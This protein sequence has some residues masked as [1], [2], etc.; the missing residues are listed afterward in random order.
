[1]LLVVVFSLMGCATAKL[2]KGQ[3]LHTLTE[4]TNSQSDETYKAE[5]DVAE[6]IKEKPSATWYK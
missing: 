2:T 1:M 3:Q 5:S 6:S 4:Q